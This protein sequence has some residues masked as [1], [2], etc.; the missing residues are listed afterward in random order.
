MVDFS[1]EIVFCFTKPTK[2]LS[3]FPLMHFIKLKRSVTS[4]AVLPKQTAPLIS[5][6]KPGKLP[7][8]AMPLVRSERPP[9]CKEKRSTWSYPGRCSTGTYP[10]GGATGGS[11]RTRASAFNTVLCA[12]TTSRCR[13]FTKKRFSERGIVKG[14]NRFKTPAMKWVS[15]L[16]QGLGNK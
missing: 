7:A 6:V 15:H 3:V 11:D 9:L 12:E 14:I 16:Q 2:T 5:L 13:M 1:L 10:Q 4:R 8:I